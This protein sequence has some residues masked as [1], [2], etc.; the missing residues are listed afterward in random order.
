MQNF[1]CAYFEWWF[2]Y[3]L[4][5]DNEFL[6]NFQVYLRVIIRKKIYLLQQIQIVI[7]MCTFY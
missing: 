4:L 7:K 2:S 5:P 3:S 6:E 1:N